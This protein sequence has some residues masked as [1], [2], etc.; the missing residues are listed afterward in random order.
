MI[1]LIG[2]GLIVTIGLFVL[3]LLY[4]KRGI[5]VLLIPLCVSLCTIYA[6]LCLKK[7]WIKP[8]IGISVSFLIE[9]LKNSAD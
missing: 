1:L 6:T 2:I 4:F 3:E 7:E 9:G 5:F 8:I